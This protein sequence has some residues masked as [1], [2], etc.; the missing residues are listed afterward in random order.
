VKQG[1]FNPYGNGQFGSFIHEIAVLWFACVLLI[2]IVTMSNFGP[3][4]LTIDWI[5]VRTE[6]LALPTF[7]YGYH[8]HTWTCVHSNGS[9]PS[10]QSSVAGTT[11][12]IPAVEI[13]TSK[14]DEYFKR[15]DAGTYHGH[16]FPQYHIAEMPKPK[17]KS[18][19]TGAKPVKL[20]PERAVERAVMRAMQSTN[21]RARN[22]P[23]PLAAGP[24]FRAGSS[25]AGFSRVTASAAPVAYGE[26]IRTTRPR[27]RA[28]K[29]GWSIQH[30][31]FAFTFV[32]SGEFCNA[33]ANID[34]PSPG[35]VN[36]GNMLLFPWLAKFASRAEMYKF[37]FLRFRIVT[38]TAT[39]EAGSI[40]MA[41][42]LDAADAAPTNPVQIMNYEG[43]AS[44]PVWS[45]ALYTTL[46]IQDAR[47][48]SN[49]RYL[50]TY[51]QATT[52][53]SSNT[54]RLND[55]A[56]F[57]LFA[58]GL[59]GDITSASLCDVYVDYD[60]DLIVPQISSPLNTSYY[61]NR[62]AAISN[63][64]WANNLVYGSA[65]SQ[66]S[67]TV[68]MGYGGP[69]R[70]AGNQGSAVNFVALGDWVIRCNWTGGVIN[71][72]GLIGLTDCSQLVYTT[73]GISNISY[74]TVRYNATVTS[75]PTTHITGL[76][77]TFGFTVTDA[78][79]SFSMTDPSFPSLFTTAPLQCSLTMTERGTLLL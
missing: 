1:S 45:N 47:V 71:P 48:A 68:P 69:V 42:D 12:S 62:V 51:Y 75:G 21:S 14:D 65:I 72:T 20:V 7:R 25:D 61:A 40:Y 46:N 54:N 31:E 52:V 19:P 6:Y 73:G 30:S 53:Q 2:T 16:V 10:S 58:G 44:G 39:S 63:D 38:K 79:N 35:R 64:D 56:N 27:I 18:K 17:P 49:T 29:D 9:R 3:V 11:T 15:R 33:F 43:A 70:P 55:V 32:A 74:G 59:G 8:S 22:R 24:K 34:S 77:F 36:P 13:S 4:D 28:T 50:A 67:G 57:Y 60:V 5:C 23:S 41:F 66:I 26:I 78:N 76:Y 37:R